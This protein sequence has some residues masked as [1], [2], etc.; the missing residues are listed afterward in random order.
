MPIHEISVAELETVLAAGA[1]LIDVRETDEYTAGH[2]SGAV[3]V[4]L[5]TV[6][7]HVGAFRGDGP[8]YVICRSGG[9]SMK[10]CEFLAQ[11]GIETINVK[12]GTLDWI[13]GGRPVVTG[14]AP[15]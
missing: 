3:L 15:A 12:G 13:A 9:R 6:P 11:Q 8:A 1:R 7:D 5:G 14:S 2:V 4:A 10:A